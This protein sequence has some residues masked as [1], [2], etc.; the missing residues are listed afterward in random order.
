MMR[1]DKPLR[2]VFAMTIRQIRELGHIMAHMSHMLWLI[3][4]FWKPFLGFYKI[5]Y[6]IYIIIAN[7]GRIEEFKRICIASIVLLCK[8]TQVGYQ[9]NASPWLVNSQLA[10]L[11]GPKWSLT[12]TPKG[13]IMAIPFHKR[14]FNFRKVKKWSNFE[15]LIHKFDP[16]SFLTL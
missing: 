10:D 4:S 1:L 11:I 15:F 2:W 9:V 5:Q 13:K 12:W 16:L 7:R 3:A 14:L 8:I 6:P